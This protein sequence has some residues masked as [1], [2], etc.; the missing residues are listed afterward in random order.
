[1]AATAYK[2]YQE[3]QV[4]TS[5]PKTLLLLLLEAS[6]SFIRAAREAINQ[7]R[8]DVKHNNIVRVQE[9]VRHLS[10]V[11][12]DD[13]AP[14]LAASLRKLYIHLDLVLTEANLEDSTEKLEHAEEILAALAAAWKQAAQQLP[15]G[16]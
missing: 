10:L 15:P 3:T 9:I 1:M 11:L 12:R 4:H 16:E 6:V 5:D 2:A 13:V 14:D 7:R 8:W